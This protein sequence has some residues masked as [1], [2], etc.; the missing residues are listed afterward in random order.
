MLFFK[1]KLDDFAFIS[2]SFFKIAFDDFT[3]RFIFRIDS[4]LMSTFEKTFQ[5]IELFNIF[6]ENDQ[7][8][9]I[10]IHFELQQKILFDDEQ[11]FNNIDTI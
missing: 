7:F 8:S 5:I 3:F 6:N 2:M 10:M 9:F 1:I 4:F 11:M